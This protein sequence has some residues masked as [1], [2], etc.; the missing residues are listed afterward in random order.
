MA[1]KELNVLQAFYDIESL[2]NVFSLC[3]YKH[4]DNLVDVY[5]LVDD[6]LDTLG[7]SSGNFVIT[8]EIKEYISARIYL[9]NK[10]H[11]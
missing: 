6:K 10:K 3:N 7:D 4:N 1:E 11:Y 2:K 5:I 9:K 8:D